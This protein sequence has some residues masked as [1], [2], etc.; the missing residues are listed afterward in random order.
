VAKKLYQ[1][2]RDF[3]HFR[4]GEV[5]EL[6]DDDPYTRTGYLAEWSPPGAEAEALESTEPPALDSTTDSTP[7]TG[8]DEAEEVGTDGDAEGAAGAGS[9][10][11]SRRRG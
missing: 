2:D 5:Y 8:T 9:G 11:R 3:D 6:E 4:V 1:A 10:P 7:E